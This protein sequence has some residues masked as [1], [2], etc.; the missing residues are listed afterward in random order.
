MKPHLVK[1][2][3]RLPARLALGLVLLLGSS[4]VTAPVL[5]AEKRL[6]IS[7]TGSEQLAVLASPFAAVKRAKNG[8]FYFYSPENLTVYEVSRPGQPVRPISLAGAGGVSTTRN[9]VPDFATDAEGNLYI[10][11]LWRD[12]PGV[13]HSTVLVIDASGSYKRGVELTPAV[14]ARHLVVLGTGDLVILGSDPEFYRGTAPH[15][16]L[17]HRFLVSGRRIKSFSDRALSADARAAGA[18][19]SSWEAAKEDVD[20]G[21]IFEQ[22]NL[23]YQVLPRSRL[24]RVFDEA[25]T[26]VRSAPLQPPAVGGTRSDRV[27]RLVVLADGR[28]LVHWVRSTTNGNV[29][30]NAPYLCL[31]DA[32]GVAIST[33]T[34]QP[35][36][37]SFPVFSDSAATC[38]FLRSL[39]GGGVDLIRT[40]LTV[41]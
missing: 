41:Q 38:Y 13:F 39:P 33:A 17:L 20:Q 40:V 7:A 9:L 25:G 29:T 12:Q 32:Q 36:P 19:G 31:H 24:V 16:Y 2:R 11:M 8:E 5:S 3:V 37:R 10:P 30:R 6:V 34:Q 14:N 26:L 1:W 15:D 4:S 18:P 35:W 23:L 21:Q 22:D 28:Y 27:W